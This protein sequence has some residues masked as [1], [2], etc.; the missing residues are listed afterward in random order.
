MK[1]NKMIGILFSMIAIMAIVVYA[2]PGEPDGAIQ[3]GYSSSNNATTEELTVTAQGGNYT[4]LNLSAN[5]Q[6]SNWQ[7]FYGTLSSELLLKDGNNN[8]AYTWTGST[9]KNGYIFF[10]NSTTIDFSF[11]SV[12][13]DNSHLEP[14]N[15]ALGLGNAADN[16]TN[17]FTATSHPLLNY[18]GNDLGE[19]TAFSVTTSNGTSDVW[20]TAVIRQDTSR[21]YVGFFNDTHNVAFNGAAANYQVLVPTGTTGRTYYVYLAL[22]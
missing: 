12:A 19:N 9:T 20:P 18:T 11:A 21:A 1:I 2:A 5:I 4:Y 7:L 6:T 17:T 15:Q 16:M 14:E 3:E 8:V 13:N 10:S 22:E